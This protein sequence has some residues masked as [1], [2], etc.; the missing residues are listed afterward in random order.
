MGYKKQSKRK[1]PFKKYTPHQKAN[2]N[3]NELESSKCI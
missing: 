2:V 3:F 1:S